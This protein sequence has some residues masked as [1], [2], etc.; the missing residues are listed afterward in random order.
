MSYEGDEKGV[1]LSWKS[2]LKSAWAARG[3]EYAGPVSDEPPSSEPSGETIGGTTE[4]DFGSETT[5]LLPD[6]VDESKLTDKQ[7]SI[8]ETAIMRPTA[9]Y[10]EIAAA[11]A[12]SPGYVIDVCGRWLPDHPAAGSVTD[13]IDSTQMS[14]S[15][16]GAV[17]GEKS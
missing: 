5:T 14:L 8:L 2:D 15:E 10:V 3:D 6:D 9:S 7:H 12:A 13:D 11:A 17:G 1:D 4:D 16:W